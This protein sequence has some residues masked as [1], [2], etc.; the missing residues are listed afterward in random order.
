MTGSRSPSIWASTRT[1]CAIRPGPTQTDDPRAR[2]VAADTGGGPLEGFSKIPE[3]DVRASAGPGALLEGFEETK[4]VWYFPDAVIRHEFRTRSGD[5]RIITIDGDSMEPVLSSGDRIMVDTSQR[6]PV[7]PGIFVIWDGMGIVAKRIEHILS[8]TRR[9][10][11]SCRS[12]PITRPMSATPRRSTSS[13]ASSGPPGDTDLN[14]SA[15]G[16]L[17][18]IAD[19]LLLLLYFLVRAG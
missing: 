15:G 19:K 13:A 16:W 17:S 1:S 14:H 5:L 9:S 4:D 8:S 18:P 6:I 2:R 12:T 7:P 3:I 11:A 10:C